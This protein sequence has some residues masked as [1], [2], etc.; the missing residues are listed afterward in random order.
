MVDNV[1]FWL[2]VLASIYTLVKTGQY[3]VHIFFP[4]KVQLSAECESYKYLEDIHDIICTRDHKGF[5]LVYHRE[6]ETQQ[7]IV[8]ALESITSTQAQVIEALQRNSENS[9]KQNLLLDHIL[10][11]IKQ[12]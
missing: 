8:S 10:E 2:L 7:R 4:P 11:T 12:K 3:I 9:I 5:P 6:S 1:D